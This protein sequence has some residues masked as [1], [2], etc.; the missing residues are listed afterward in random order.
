MVMLLGP[1]RGQICVLG[2]EFLAS[3][4]VPGL[5]SGQEPFELGLRGGDRND[6]EAAGAVLMAGGLWWINLQ[7]AVH[8]L[9]PDPGDSTS[10]D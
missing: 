8:R 7:Q 6:V 2:V 10:A 5:V 3:R 9:A 4:Q 1:I